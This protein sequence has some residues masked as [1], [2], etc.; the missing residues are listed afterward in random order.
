MTGDYGADEVI[1]SVADKGGDQ[2]SYHAKRIGDHGWEI[3]GGRWR[4]GDC[5][6]SASPVIG[7]GTKDWSDPIT[8]TLK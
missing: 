2:L 4:A 8:I 1:V 6:V 5:I 3:N 7:G